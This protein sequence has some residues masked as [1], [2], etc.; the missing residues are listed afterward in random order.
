MLTFILIHLFSHE[1][2]LMKFS[3]EAIHLVRTILKHRQLL[4]WNSPLPTL[5]NHFQSAIF[6]LQIWAHL[7]P[8]FLNIVDTR[9]FESI[10]WGIGV[11]N[12][13]NSLSPTIAG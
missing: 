10:I 13:A 2:L 1:I 8:G 4:L 7:S 5:R 3:S 11:H 9:L 12:L 6:V